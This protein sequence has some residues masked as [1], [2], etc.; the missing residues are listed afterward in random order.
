MAILTKNI[1]GK[2]VAPDGTGWAGG[3][4]Y[5]SLNVSGTVD[6][7]GTE[8]VI[9][10][11]KVYIIQEDGTVNFDLVP[12]DIITPADCVYVVRYFA[13]NGDRIA[14]Y[15]RVLSTD[16][17]PLDIGDITRVVTISG[18]FVGT[19]LLGLTDTNV[20]LPI[21][22]EYV[23]TWDSA[24]EKWIPAPGGSGGG[25]ATAIHD[26]QTDEIHQVTEKVTPANDDE[27]LI[28][29]SAA[30]WAKKRV[31]VSNL[32]GGGGGAQDEYTTATK[33]AAIAA[34][35]NEPFV[36]KDPGEHAHGEIIYQRADSSY[37]YWITWQPF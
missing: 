9:G 35:K 34:N 11:T 5:I 25:D 1:V 3:S 7:A 37:A 36:V 29:D 33:P 23:L 18:G 16:S 19:T 26:N 22:D 20:P 30:A 10:G 27:V 28:E 32:P 14:E 13:P 31:K 4:L 2:I 24:T 15:W 6:D 21:T 12:N 8:Q 17:S